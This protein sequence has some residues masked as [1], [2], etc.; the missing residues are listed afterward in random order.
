MKQSFAQNNSR[1][2]GYWLL[3]GVVMLLIQVALGG[4]TRL[5]G[6]GLSITEWNVVTGTLPPL[7]QS[8][9]TQEFD[10]YK[11]TPQFRLL[12]EDFQL[13]NFKF[14][15]FYEWLHRFWARLV[16]VV[17]IVGFVWLLWRKKMRPQMLRPMVIL[18]LLGAIQGAV[19]WL[20]VASGL[21][22]DAIY[23]QPTR[24]ALHFIFALGLLCYT[25]W[26]ALSLLEKK[27]RLDPAQKLR[28][29]TWIILVL[30]F[31]QLI[32]G[33]LMAGHH[34]AAVAPTWPRLNGDWIPAGLFRNTPALLN[35]INNPITI[36]FI[37]RL[38]AY[39]LFM[40]TF[41]WTLRA[42]HVSGSRGSHFGRA[43]LVP[44]FL[45][46]IQIILGIST[47]LASRGIVANRWVI[48]DWLAAFHQMTGMLFLLSIVYL[49]YLLQPREVS[50]V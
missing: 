39:L 9:W 25:F 32:Y 7:N 48:F 3:L 10:K 19:G 15:F 46:L 26:F 27:E 45:I 30:L 22:G 2:V 47:V 43:R 11:Q 24:L 14:I 4:V 41:F 44:L 6:S 28:S 34:A 37:H 21:T 16:G 35:L 18:F 31:F 1:A 5:T 40:L 38:L 23:V 20:M 33:A 42:M 13:S 29:L 50:T 49:L 36:Q 8:E 17:F 12:H